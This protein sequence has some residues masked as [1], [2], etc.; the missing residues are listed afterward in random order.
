MKG[1]EQLALDAGFSWYITK[2]V[3]T[4]VLPAI[5]VALIEQCE[6]ERAP[7]EPP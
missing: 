5:I 3:D 7:S 4:R 2:P 1:D 6:H